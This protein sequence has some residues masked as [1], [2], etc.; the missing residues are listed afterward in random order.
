[1]SLPMRSVALPL[2]SSPHWAPISTIAGIGPPRPPRT[3][4]GLDN[5]SAAGRP[6]AAD[7]DSLASGT[8]HPAVALQGRP[9][10]AAG[11]AAVLVQERGD[12]PPDGPQPD[13][14]RARDHLVLR[15][16]RQHPDQRI[17]GPTRGHLDLGRD[18]PHDLDPRREAPHERGVA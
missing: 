4:A 17:V 11:G 18:G 8:R 15:P 3:G 7:R 12:A 2:P 5:T 10:L 6:A 13:V 1:T 9:E 16:E 14:Q